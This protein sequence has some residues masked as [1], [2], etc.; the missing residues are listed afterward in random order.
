MPRGVHIAHTCMDPCVKPQTQA[1]CM[2][3]PQAPHRSLNHLHRLPPPPH[4][5]ITKHHTGICTDDRD[6]RSAYM[7]SCYYNISCHDQGP[8]VYHTI[9]VAIHVELIGLHIDAMLCSGQYRVPGRVSERANIHTHA[10]ALC[11]LCL[12]HIRALLLVA[13]STVCSHAVYFMHNSRLHWTA[14]YDRHTWITRRFALISH[15]GP[16]DHHLGCSIRGGCISWSSEGVCAY[17]DI[18]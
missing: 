3:L 16:P 2:H 14:R 7:G 17:I 12:R 15:D 8:L 9:H 1:H 4:L 5:D 13:I 18:R 10:P 11:V 6:G